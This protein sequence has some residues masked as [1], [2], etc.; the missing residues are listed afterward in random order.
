MD[1]PPNGG[2]FIMIIWKQNRIIPE[3]LR[4]IIFRRI[5]KEHNDKEKFYTSYNSSTF[6]DI[7]DA[8]GSSHTKL[9]VYSQTVCRVYQLPNAITPRRKATVSNPSQCRYNANHAQ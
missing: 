1:H 5:E 3:S 4:S 8:A 7:I 9:E 2:F 6:S